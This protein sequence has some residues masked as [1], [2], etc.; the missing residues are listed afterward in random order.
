MSGGSGRI[1]VDGQT[2]SQGGGE[3]ALDS[4]GCTGRGA[5]YV[6]EVVGGSKRLAVTAS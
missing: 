1:E 5:R 3:V 2:L 6:I 4:A